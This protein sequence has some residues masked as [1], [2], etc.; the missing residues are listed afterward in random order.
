[1]DWLFLV[2]STVF[3]VLGT[4]AAKQSNGLKDLAASAQMILCY[5]LSLSGLSFAMRSI[6]MSIAYPVWTGTASLVISVLGIILFHE[7]MSLFK[8]FSI[9]LVIIGLIGLTMGSQSHS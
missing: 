6:E 4:L 5:G 3:E 8:G 2:A 1:M 9:F 7:S